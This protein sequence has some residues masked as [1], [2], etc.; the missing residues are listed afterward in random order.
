MVILFFLL[1]L[2]EYTRVTATAVFDNPRN[3]GA[4]FS[5]TGPVV[6][7]TLKDELRYD[8]EGLLGKGQHD[9]R[10]MRE[11]HYQTTE[12]VEGERSRGH[13][14]ES[15]RWFELSKLRPSWFLT[16]QSERAPVMPL[17]LPSLTAVKLVIAH[18]APAASPTP[19]TLG[20]DGKL[21][22]SISLRQHTEDSKPWG[23]T[24]SPLQLLR[25]SLTRREDRYPTSTSAGCLM[26]TWLQGTL[27]FSRPI[28]DIFVQPSYTFTSDNRSATDANSPRGRLS[29]RFLRGTSLDVQMSLATNSVLVTVPDSSPLTSQSS[30]RNRL[31]V[32][33]VN[34]L[35]LVESI[36]GSFLFRLPFAAVS[37]LRLSPWLHRSMTHENYLRNS[38]RS[39]PFP[40][41]ATPGTPTVRSDDYFTWQQPAAESETP[42]VQQRIPPTT[43]VSAPSLPPVPVSSSSGGQIDFGCVA[44]A[45]AGGAGRTRAVL[46]LDWNSPSLAV[47]HSV[48]ARHTVIPEICL[49]SGRIVYQWLIDFDQPASSASWL[50]DAVRWPMSSRILP[51]RFRRK[52]LE[53]ARK[54]REQELLMFP[55]E[56]TVD[57][58]GAQGS[59]LEAQG[60]IGEGRLKRNGL[61]RTFVDPTRV[62][63]VTWTDHSAADTGTWTTDLK[64]PLEESSFRGLLGADIRVRR[65]FCF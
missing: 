54:Q 38:V 18:D 62:I 12:N 58:T 49:R 17:W 46:Q 64:I 40:S 35:N 11:F 39:A 1:A 32:K 10:E 45:I 25:R 33:G 50:Q 2:K 3:G 4:R 56:V 42:A 21:I 52:Q 55:D 8:G 13:R 65:Q 63:H 31:V 60:S 24:S 43:T 61:L 51:G 47:V 14:L 44:E 7:L 59:P 41:I 36:S 53:V 28:G 5:V 30:L 26:P 15:Y 34:Y 48:D 27:H 19:Q 57:E 29:L 37:G 20:N 23:W 16:A 6:T 22:E 9:D